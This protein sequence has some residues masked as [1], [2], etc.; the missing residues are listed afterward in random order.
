MR[1]FERPAKQPRIVATAVGDAAGDAEDVRSPA[2]QRP[3]QILILEDD[4]DT[5]EMLELVLGSDGGFEVE[6]VHDVAGCLERLRASTNN[7]D[8]APFE[9]LL[10]DL[11]LCGGR[12]GTEILREAARPG[13]QLRLPPV[14]ICTGYSGAY[15]SSHVP[16]VAASQARVLSKPFDIDDLTAELRAAAR[17]RPSHRS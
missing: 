2:A 10:L 16:E 3:I 17:G 5:G 9:A 14:V 12:R 8:V 4:L 13:T 15:L 7:E 11:V 6:I 1:S